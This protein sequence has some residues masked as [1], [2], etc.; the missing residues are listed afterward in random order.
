MSVLIDTS[1]WIEYFRNTGSSADDATRR[2]IEAVEP[3]V[4]CGPVTMEVTAG[5]RDDTVLDVITSVLMRGV[6]V[7]TRPHYFDDASAVYRECRGAGITI[8]SMID[9]LVAVVALDND[10]ELLHHDRDFDAIASVLPLRV[11]PASL[12]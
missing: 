6:T 7:A 5:A 4:N 1:A 12:S 11:H 8:R 3:F 9:C 10:L 2:Q